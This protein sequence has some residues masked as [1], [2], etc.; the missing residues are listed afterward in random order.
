VLDVLLGLAQKTMSNYAN[1][2]ADTPVDAGMQTFLWERKKP[3]AA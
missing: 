1:H 3:T 2:I